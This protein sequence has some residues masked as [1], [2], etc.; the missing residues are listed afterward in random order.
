MESGLEASLR[1][2]EDI[3]AIKQL[4]AQYCS[5]CDDQ[6]DVEGLAGLFT[7]DAVWDG[8]ILGV[9]SVD[10]GSSIWGHRRFGVRSAGPLAK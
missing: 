5:Y 6:Y 4:K 3:E 7:D 9:A 10:L 2:L 8:G 1:R